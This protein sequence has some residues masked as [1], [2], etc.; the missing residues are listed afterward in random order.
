M[1]HSASWAPQRWRFQEAGRLFPAGRRGDQLGLALEVRG[2]DGA[3]AAAVLGGVERLVGAGDDLGL[4]S[5]VVRVAGHADRQRR[6]ERP[7]GRGEALLLDLLP[8]P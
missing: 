3:I 2:A 5:R 6:L 7:L 1:S 8:D 4:L